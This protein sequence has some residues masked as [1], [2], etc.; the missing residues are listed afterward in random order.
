MR[1][2]CKG[3]SAPEH[4]GL[5]ASGMGKPAGAED[6]VPALPALGLHC[7]WSNPRRCHCQRS[8]SLGM[9]LSFTW[10]PQPYPAA[11]WGQPS[12]GA[13]GCVLQL[14]VTGGHAVSI[15]R[16]YPQAWV[17]TSHRTVPGWVLEPHTWSWPGG[18]APPP[19]TVLSPIVHVVLYPSDCPLNHIV[20]SYVG[21]HPE[22]ITLLG[23]VEL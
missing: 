9:G 7:W 4:E 10:C 2:K 1:G 22:L 14:S 20:T 18:T 16:H 11:L 15:L 3:W 13:Y 8:P 21:C 5:Q 23:R 19:T 12:P 17:R 6:P